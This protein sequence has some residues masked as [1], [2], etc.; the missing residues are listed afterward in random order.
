M[1]E[2]ESLTE[3]GEMDGG[4]KEKRGCLRLSLTEGLLLSLYTR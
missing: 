1:I 4:K 2:R 3:R